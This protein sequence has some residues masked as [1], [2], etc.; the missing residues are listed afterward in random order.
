MRELSLRFGELSTIRGEGGPL[1]SVYVLDEVGEP[2]VW[3]QILR[4]RGC[5][6]DFFCS[7]VLG[8][9]LYILEDGSAGVL[10]GG[11]PAPS[12]ELGAEEPRIVQ[13]GVIVM[14]VITFWG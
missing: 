1:Y 9:D 7:T 11:F 2:G 6:W 5:F 3:V 12:L 10:G 8:V 14:E 13:G 4:F